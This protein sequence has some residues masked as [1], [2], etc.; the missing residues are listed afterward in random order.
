MSIKILSERLPNELVDKIAKLVYELNLMDVHR[1]MGI[2]QN[3][4]NKYVLSEVIDIQD[5]LWIACD[6]LDNSIDETR[7][8]NKEFGYV[9]C[10]CEEENCYWN[11]LDRINR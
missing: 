1:S 6:D 7:K 11:W 4:D 5:Y 3:N 9:I 2:D 10:N 8:E